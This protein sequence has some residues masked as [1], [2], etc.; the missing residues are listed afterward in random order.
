MRH[1]KLLNRIKEIAC[2]ITDKG[3]FL[4]INQACFA[5]WGFTP[6]EVTGTHFSSYIINEDRADFCNAFQ[7]ILQNKKEGNLKNRLRT[8]KGDIIEMD[9]TVLWDE[10]DGV[11]YASGRD[12]T[13]RSKAEDMIRT[14]SLVAS[15]T[16]NAVMITDLD[17][18]IIYT[19]DSFTRITGYTFDEVKGRSAKEI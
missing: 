19:N 12:I 13:A 16:I 7:Q 1:D 10:A 11:F 9:W 15:E 3:E 5:L 2:T 14:L 4:F 18:R 8:K 17:R 6:E